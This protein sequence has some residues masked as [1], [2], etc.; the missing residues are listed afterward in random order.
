MNLNEKIDKVIKESNEKV[1]MVI[2]DINSD[3]YLYYLNGNHKVV[4][5]STIKVPIMLAILDKVKENEIELNEKILVSQEDILNDTEVFENGENYYSLEELINWM[6]IKSDNTATNI[7][8]K[9]FSMEYLNNYISNILELKSTYLERYMLDKKAILN[10]LNNYTNQEDMN[11]T[12]E[13][14]FRKEILNKQLCNKAIDILYNQRSQDRIM[15]YIYEP[16]KFAH[17]TGSLDYLCHDVGVMNIRNKYIYIGISIYDS[18][19]KNG[20]KKLIGTLGKIIY[21]NLL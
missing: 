5:A 7:L 4:S 12:F 13:K 19:Y 10:G 6:I 21:E 8:I 11:Q 17:K 20:N 15:R 16:V 2:K 9:I 18:K 1:S 3:N 14:L